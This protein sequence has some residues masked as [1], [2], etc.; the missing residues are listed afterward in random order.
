MPT[1]TLMS[2]PCGMEISKKKNVF[3]I[4]KIKTC[5]TLG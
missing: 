4:S 1:N 3:D 2:E 5:I